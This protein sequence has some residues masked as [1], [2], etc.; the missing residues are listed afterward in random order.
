VSK[1]G[2]K[3]PERTLKLSTHLPA[4]VDGG[5]VAL[6]PRAR[7]LKPFDLISAGPFLETDRV[8]KL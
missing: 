8:S 7:P 4:L 3:Y 2:A 5:D 1:F 6:H